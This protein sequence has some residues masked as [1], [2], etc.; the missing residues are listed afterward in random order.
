MRVL[1]VSE[2]G[3]KLRVMAVAAAL[4]IPLAPAPALAWGPATHTQVLQEATNA[5]PG[6]LK[7]F[8]QHHRLEIPSLSPSVRPAP[9]GPERRFA[10][11]RLLPFPFRELP[12]K[13]DEV[14][15]RFGDE[16]KG[17]GRLPWLIQESYPKLVA[18]YRDN[19]KEAI[20][21]ESDTLAGLI[22]D[23]HNPLALTDNAD[24]QKSGQPGLWTRFAEKFPARSAH[25]KFGADGAY[26]IDD[27]ATYVFSI[28]ASTYVW[29]DNVLYADEQARRQD[30]SYGGVYYESMDRHAGTILRDR[31]SWAARDVASYWYTAWIAAGKPELR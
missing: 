11:D 29:L 25:I 4:G 10:V 9:E 6:A 20:L 17:V 30:P 16:A 5:L 23:L 13:E 14:I 2:G 24:G 28:V 12:H 1:T 7:G 19:D 31:L 8:Y 21:R 27:P 26:L 22:T 3:M 18:A 15:K